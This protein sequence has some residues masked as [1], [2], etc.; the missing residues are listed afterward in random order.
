MDKK[1]YQLLLDVALKHKP[2]SIRKKGPRS[3]PIEA[4]EIG[5]L[6]LDFSKTKNSI[7]LG[8]VSH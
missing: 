7:Y 3:F 2:Y 4:K 5:G 1:F 8:V 6:S